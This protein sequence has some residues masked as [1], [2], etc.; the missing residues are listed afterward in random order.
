MRVK[1]PVFDVEVPPKSEDVPVFC[2]EVGNV[3]DVALPKRLPVAAG[4]P[5]PKSPP[6]A[7]VVAAPPFLPWE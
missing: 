7:E 2:A 3:L 5:L 4:V 1:V 6:L